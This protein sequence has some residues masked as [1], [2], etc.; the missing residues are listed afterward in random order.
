MGSPGIGAI[1]C[2]FRLKY[3][4]NNACFRE[5]HA[6]QAFIAFSRLRKAKV[7]LFNETHDV[8]ADYALYMI[9]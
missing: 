6:N 3:P 2:S 5:N 8:G 1:G 9:P 4:A 7:S